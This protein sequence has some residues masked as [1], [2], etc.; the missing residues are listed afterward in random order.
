MEFSILLFN[1]EDRSSH[2]GLGG[3]DPSRFEVFL[4][5]GVQ[6]FLFGGKEQVDLATFR[7]SIV[8]ELDG[9]VPRL[10]PRYF[11][12]GVLGEYR[13]EVAEVRRD[14]LFMIRGLGVL[15]ESFCQRLGNRSGRA[16][17]FHLGEES[18]C[19][20][21]VAFFERFI[22]EV[23]FW[24][25]SRLGFI[26]LISIFYEGWEGAGLAGVY[27]FSILPLCVPFHLVVGLTA[28]TAAQEASVHFDRSGTEV[29][30]QIVL[31]QPGEAEY[32]ALLAEAGDREQNAFRVLVVGHDHVDDFADAPGLV[33]C[34][35]HIVN[36]DRLGQLA[37][38]KFRLGDEVLVDEVS[39]GASI[40]H[41]LHG[42]FFH[43][44]RRL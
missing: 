34:S 24:V 37:G 44:V 8:G 42:C 38:R 12:E 25:G 17:V 6:F 9:M 21:L 40:D 23:S 7:R 10:G 11:I 32:H 14:V 27:L 19:P 30:L 26:F 39:G 18:G 15:S 5:K 36:R 31:V 13:V 43:G 28:D 16:D 35:V 33:K 29:D 1:K 22:W 41:G 4:Q 20:D 3:S 2:R